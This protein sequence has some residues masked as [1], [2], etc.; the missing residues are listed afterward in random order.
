MNS[1]Y[2]PLIVVLLVSYA[3]SWIVFGYLWSK[4][5]GPRKIEIAIR[6]RKSPAQ[7]RA[8]LSGTNWIVAL[9]SAFAMGAALVALSLKYFGTWLAQE[10]YSGTLKYEIAKFFFNAVFKEDRTLDGTNII[11]IAWGC[12]LSLFFG[13]FVG[14]IVGKIWG[15]KKAV[16]KYHLTKLLFIK[17]HS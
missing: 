1:P 9:V 8:A 6:D 3:V 13:V 4:H 2:F 7:I 10:L 11:F 16:L 17:K 15:V 12:A 14:A 5:L